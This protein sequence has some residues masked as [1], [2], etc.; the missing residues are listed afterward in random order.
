MS[1]LAPPMP[2]L[3]PPC[4]NV[5]AK[6][7]NISFAVDTRLHGQS[8][9]QYVCVTR[10]RTHTL[11][12]LSHRAL[13]TAALRAALYGIRYEGMRHGVRLGYSLAKRPGIHCTSNYTAW[14]QMRAMPVLALHVPDIT[15]SALLL[16]QGYT[17]IQ[18]AGTC[19][20]HGS[21]RIRLHACRTVRC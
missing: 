13:S 16:T 8:A 7:A 20:E 10:Q 11:A 3:A 2:V 17:V 18:R 15:T 4:L 12:R 1:V 19:A 9:G 6:Y 21:V 14:A 5:H